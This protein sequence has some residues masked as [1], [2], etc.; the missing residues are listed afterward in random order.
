MRPHPAADDNTEEG[1]RGNIHRHYDLSN[2]LFA[3]FLD[4]TMTYSSALFAGTGDCRGPATGSP[5]ARL[6]AEPARKI[7]RLLDLARVGPATRVLE[8][9]TGWGELAIRAAAARR[10][11]PHGDAVRASSAPRRASGSTAAGLADRV[12]VRAAGLP[13]G[14][15]RVRRDRV[16]G[17]DRGGGR[18]LLARPTS[19]RWTGCSP[20]AAGSACSRSPC[21]TAGCS[22][23]GTPTPGCS[24]YIFPGGLIPSV[25]GDRAT[26]S[27]TPA[28]GSPS[29]ST[30]AA[31]YARDAA[32]LAGAVQR[33]GGRLPGLGFDDVFRRMWQLYLAYSEAGFRSGYLDVSQ[34]LLVKEAP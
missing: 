17:D 7:D 28:C 13:R 23:P 10:P 18:A 30:S 21:R 4:E 31:H 25:H 27:P 2:E 11:G 9:G 29:G 24:K 20:R 26:P 15:R 1:A 3:L 12:T 19:R 6:L 32:D 5:D 34:F 14:D 8:I 22:P 33:P 16:G